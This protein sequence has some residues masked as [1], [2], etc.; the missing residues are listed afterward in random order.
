MGASMEIQG[1]FPCGAGADFSRTDIRSPDRRQG[2]SA[3]EMA[4][5]LGCWDWTAPPAIYNILQV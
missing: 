2:R 5:E 4:C 3:L 1:K